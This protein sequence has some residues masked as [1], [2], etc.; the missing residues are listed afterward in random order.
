MRPSIYPDI[1]FESPLFEDS[2]VFSSTGH[3][4]HNFLPQ[5][6]SF[7]VQLPENYPSSFEESNIVEFCT[8]TSIEESTKQFLS[9]LL[10]KGCRYNI[11]FKALKEL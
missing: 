1:L 3:A 11:P 10:E 8:D 7:T 4:L 2:S 6:S 9:I 5:E